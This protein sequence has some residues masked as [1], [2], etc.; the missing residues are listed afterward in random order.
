[1]ANIFISYSTQDRT[2]A[3]KL[4]DNFRARGYSVWMDETNI[5]AAT[6][7]SSEIVRAIEASSVFIILLSH[8]SVGSH[9]VIK[10]LSLASEKKKHIIPVELEPTEIPHDLQYQLAG[11][12]RVPYSETAR[13]EAAVARFV[14]GTPTMPEQIAKAST[15]T[16]AN[17]GFGK[18]WLRAGVPIALI[19]IAAGVYFFAIKK[20]S[21]SVEPV[22]ASSAASARTWRV[23]VL[24]FESL[25]SNKDDEYFAEGVTASLISTLSP[26]A[27]IRVTNRKT[28][29]EYKGKKLDPKTIATEL[30][31]RFL[32]DGTVQKDAQH[33][34]INVQLIDT[35]N[36]KTIF[37]D[38]FDGP[39]TDALRTQDQL[40]RAIAFELQSKL[41]VTFDSSWYLGTANQECYT[42]FMQG[43]QYI[44]NADSLQHMAAGL[45]LLEKASKLD[46][47][48]A[49]PYVMRANYY[50]QRFATLSHD[51]H[52]IEIIDSLAKY[53]ERTDPNF[54]YANLLLA[55]VAS[56]RVDLEGALQ[57]SMLF[58]RKQPDD[59]LGYALAA[60]CYYAKRDFN[61]TVTFEQ[62]VIK[63]D[64]TRLWDWNIL[65]GCLQS[66]GATK[67]RDHYID[68]AL[69]LFDRY[70]EKH[71]SSLSIRIWYGQLLAYTNDKLATH[72]QV[73]K[74]LQSDHLETTDYYNLA[75]IYSV[76]NEPVPAISMLKTALSNGYRSVESISTDPDFK[77]IRETPAFKAL[78]KEADTKAAPLK[79]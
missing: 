4:C 62:E 52:D 34:K 78:L 65:I 46:P 68:L 1:M 39:L 17:V 50:F 12:Q 77:N 37:A 42:A 66:L 16:K 59:A 7:W 74:I 15:R 53:I 67:E 29:M 18:L 33:V 6:Q 47:K 10:E 13:I 8:S 41:L 21:I 24:P 58:I 19:L 35:K 63:Q 27:G 70:L 2:K 64:I 49:W 44:E 51:P 23:A 72:R 73:E 76:L 14:G 3:T 36:G 31:V 5:S 56:V 11:I 55:Q 60:K 26:L 79:P 43:A 75:C 28:A 69:P 9:N 71:P 54:A 30:G 48:F 32:V 25:S 45:A 40:A 61:K 20:G 57:Q 22:S 38:D